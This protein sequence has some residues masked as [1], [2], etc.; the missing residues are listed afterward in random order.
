MPTLVIA[1]TRVDIMSNGTDL[2]TRPLC[3]LIPD[4]R[5]LLVVPLYPLPAVSP[6]TGMD[7]GVFDTVTECPPLLDGPRSLRRHLRLSD[8]HYLETSRREQFAAARRTLEDLMRAH[9]IDR[10]AV[11]GAEVAELVADVRGCPKVL[12]L[13]D[14][15]AL[16]S[17]RAIR[18]GGWNH[19]R[20]F[21]ELVDLWR[22]RRTE[23]RLPE[24]F[25][26]VVTASA[27]DTAEI[28]RLCGGRT[29][30]LTVP[31]GVDESYLAPLPLPGH[32][33]AVVF[34]GNLD[35]EPNIAALRYF[36]DEVWSPR[37]RSEGVAVLVVGGNAPSW[38]ERMAEREPLIR[39][40][41]FVS[42][43]RA[44]VTSYPVMINPMQTGSGI[45]NKVL[46]AFGMGIVVVS[47]PRGVEAMPDVID[48]VHLAIADGGDAFAA[49]VLD[50]LDD[51][52]RRLRLRANANA[53]LHTCYPWGVAAAGWRDLFEV[54]SLETTT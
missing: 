6:S 8:D 29:N 3:E 42:D 35:F 7:P 48:G 10:I 36:F 16:R 13:C 4:A 32:R 46:E 2:R 38:L 25:D 12:D 53:L 21:G 44:A 14:S 19:C 15:M 43:L 49:A 41:G 26:Q 1:S 33:R 45:K 30:V 27:A 23:S 37:L 54:G 47:T 51:P 39:L 50:L 31:N 9:G 5:H 11:F 28:K 17:S 40:S 34:W 20:V 52:A 18:H 22:V 24:L